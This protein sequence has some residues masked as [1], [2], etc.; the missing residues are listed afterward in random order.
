MRGPRKI[1]YV[2]LAIQ[3]SY[4]V[5]GVSKNF[6]LFTARVPDGKKN[7]KQKNKKSMK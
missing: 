7:K 5:K 6:L 1:D 4:K 3:K 2:F